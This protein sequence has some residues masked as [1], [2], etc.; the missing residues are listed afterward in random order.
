LKAWQPA[1]CGWL[2]QAFDTFKYM[3]IGLH[4]DKTAFPNLALMKLSAWHHAQ[5]D[6]VSVYDSLFAAHYDKVYSS[7]VFTFTAEDRELV[8]NIE[9]GGT[10]YK[11]L[12]TLPEEIEHMCPD[13]A[14]YGLDYSLGFL[15]RGCYRNCE[16]CC[17]PMKEGHIRAHADIDEFLQ[18]DRVVLMDNNVLASEHGIQ[19]IEKFVR[20]GVKVDFNQGLDA[21]LIDDTMARLLAKVKWLSPIRL[22]CDSQSQMP[23]VLNAVTLLRW[24]NARPS[25][26]FVYCLVKDVSE[27]M[28]RVK[29][30]KGLNLDP[31]AQPFID[32]EGGKRPSR[33]QLEFARWVNHKAIFNS[34]EFTN[35]DV[36][37]KGKMS[38]KRLQP[39][40]KDGRE[41][42]A[43][44]PDGS[45]AP[46]LCGG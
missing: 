29:F 1:F 13:Y 12:N 31:F 34:V 43:L 15:T 18:H 2:S 16:W 33:S 46:V 10:G 14:L 8:G 30:L 21:R 23:S 7:K 35:Y 41:N 44:F 28:E 6:D 40:P 17:V 22:A 19:Q 38:N 32:V 24:H 3:R 39:T 36:N 9:K 25:K 27:A 37:A 42:L 26:Y 11:L 5:G 45:A 4:S 20:L